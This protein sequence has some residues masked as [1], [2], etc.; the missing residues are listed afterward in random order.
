MDLG[1]IKANLERG[2]YQTIDEFV[3]H[4]NLV[5]KNAC[6][7]NPP[8]S[9]VYIMAETLRE[10]FTTKFAPSLGADVS[11]LTNSRAIH[12]AVTQEYSEL[13][14]S[15]D[16]M[17]KELQQLL[18][19]KKA[20][21]SVAEKEEPIPMTREEK[22]KLS[23]DINSLSS[24][25]LTVVVKIIKNKMPI[26]DSSDEIVIDIDS[27]DAATLR[28]LETYIQKV[29]KEKEVVTEELPDLI[30]LNRLIATTTAITLS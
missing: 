9:D 6:T 8:G 29:K 30:K 24:E 16:S 19:D 20:V 4:V 13:K 27:L 28:E 7:Y 1:T 21:I 23:S 14:K 26:S 5:F 17:K 11:L 10:I 18:N 25:H 12:P 15:V 22:K 3:D 2:D